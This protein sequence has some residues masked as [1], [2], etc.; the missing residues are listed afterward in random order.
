MTFEIL[1][2]LTLSSLA[3]TVNN[4]GANPQ[5]RAACFHM[6]SARIVTEL[7]GAGLLLMSPDERAEINL[8]MSFKSEP[9]V[10]EFHAA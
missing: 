5:D 8:A 7:N 6:L 2:L 9:I 10:G 4:D 3:S 1:G